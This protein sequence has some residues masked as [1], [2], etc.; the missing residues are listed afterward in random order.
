MSKKTINKIIIFLVILFFNITKA[1]NIKF[2]SPEASIIFDSKRTYFAAPGLS[3]IQ[4]WYKQNLLQE[5]GKQNINNFGTTLTYTNA[6]AQQFNNF[7]YSGFSKAKLNLYYPNPYQNDDVVLNLYENTIFLNNDIEIPDLANFIITT[8]GILDGQNKSIILGRNSQIILDTFTSVT[9][10][11]LTLKRTTNDTQLWQLRNSNLLPEIFCAGYNA[12][13]TFDNCQTA[14]SE[15]F[16]ISSGKIYINNNFN[17]TGTNKF[18]CTTSRPVNILNQSS[19]N[20][21]PQTAFEFNPTF[22]SKTSLN[23]T[24]KS[25]KI[26]L[27]NSSLFITNTGLNLTKGTLYFDNNVTISTLNIYNKNISGINTSYATKFFGDR[28]FNVKWHPF[29][30]TFAAGGQNPIDGYELRLVNQNAVY[31]DY[32]GGIFAVDYG[33]AVYACEWSPDGNYL[34]IG[35]NG[36]ISG[37]EL[38]IYSWTDDM[39]ISLNYG[40][41]IYALAWSPDNNY[42]AVGGVNPD[43]GDTLK[44]YKFRNN[45]A[46]LIASAPYTGTI[47]SIDWSPDGNMLIFAGSNRMHVYE[48]NGTDLTYLI[49]ES[50]GGTIRS[51]AFSPDGYYIAGTILSPG[52]NNAVKI[53]TVNHPNAGDIIRIYTAI[54]YGIN[55]YSA[56]WSHDGRYLAVGGNNPTSGNELQIYYFNGRY[57]SL[58]DSK[59]YGHTIFSVD[60][61]YDD[62]YL[63]IGGQAPDALHQEIEVYHFD[64]I[65]YSP[66]ATSNGLTL[67]N[68]SIGNNYNMDCIPLGNSRV[69]VEN[70]LNMN[71]TTT[72]TNNLN[73][74]NRYANLNLNKNTSKLSI[75][76]KAGL[77]GWSQESIINENNP[78]NNWINNNT[79]YGYSIGE[80]KPTTNIVT[81]NSNTIITQINCDIKYNSNAII[82]TQNNDIKNNSNSILNNKTKIRYNSNAIISVDTGTLDTACTNNS[83]AIISQDKRI[84]YNSNAIINNLKP[85]RYNSNAIL[86]LES[87]LPYVSN[88]TINNKNNINYNSSAIINNK[89]N[90]SYNSNAIINNINNLNININKT[91]YNSNA[92][93]THE[94]KIKY[95]SNAILNL[96]NKIKYNSNAILDLK[97]Q[98][99]YISN[100][101][102][103]N[104]NYINYNSS[105]IINNIKYINYNSNAIINNINNLNININKTRYNSSAIII[106]ENKIRY[107]SNAIVSV[108]VTALEEAIKHNSDAIVSSENIILK[109][110]ILNNS[111]AILKHIIDIKNNSNTIISVSTPELAKKIEYNSNAIIYFYDIEL[112]EKIINNSNAIITHKKEIK[113]NSDAIVSVDL[114]V[115]AQNITNNSNA[116]I[117]HED[118]IKYNSNAIINNKNNIKYNSN[119]IINN[120]NNIN[121][122]S[123]AIINN[124]NNINYNS[125]AIINNKN[126]INYNSNAIINNKNNIIINTNNIR[127]NS[128][129][130]IINKNNI[131]YNSCAIINLNYEELTI[132][133][134]NAI[135]NLKTNINY[136]SNATIFNNINIKNNSNAIISYNITQ[137]QNNIRY[138][139]EAIIN[140]QTSL[141]QDRIKNNS[142]A[143]ITLIPKVHYNSQAIVT[144]ANAGYTNFYEAIKHNS[145]ALL[146]S[147]AM[148]FK[149]KIRYNSNAIINILNTSVS[150]ALTKTPITGN[151][152]LDSSVFIHP[153]ERIYI[154]DNAIIDGRGAVIIFGSPEHAQLVVAENKTVTFKNIQLLRI[155]QNT[156]DLRYN[157]YVDGLSPSGYRLDEGSI[158]LGQNVLFGLSENITMTQG[159]IE[160]INNDASQAQTFKFNGIEGQKQFQISPS[161]NYANALSLADN[162]LTWQNRIDNVTPVIPSQLPT[163]WAQND[164]SPILIKFNDNTFGIQDINFSGLQHVS[165]T[166]SLNYTGALGLLGSAAVDVGNLTYEDF[167]QNTGIQE[168]YDMVFVT[169][170]INN[171]LRLLKDNLLFTGQLQ[172][173]DYDENVLSIDSVLT[174]RISPD[175]LSPDPDRTIPL[176]NFATDFLQLTSNY[177][178]ARLIFDDSRIRIFNQTDAFKVYENSYLGGKTIEITGDP[179]WDL[180]NPNLGG[181]EFVLDVNELIGLDDI[182]NKPIVSLYYLFLKNNNLKNNNKLKTALDLVCE[183]EISNILN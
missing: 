171:I 60:W 89:N 167:L 4:G 105:A 164:T 161:N 88:A 25:S 5:Y 22:S 175:P 28:I 65:P 180:Y 74:A 86:N 48:F 160:L 40:Q 97:S 43:T 31:V 90:I 129:S 169:Q 103:N 91:R 38:Q 66:Q 44:I 130:I 135:I 177:G 8:S 54:N 159:L 96:N 125:S 123:S 156:I 84:T 3:S 53:Y 157:V 181:K 174:E 110:K 64:Y 95:N 20:I 176:V 121:Y 132:N 183:Q 58:I 101:T 98:L 59:N 138:N 14:F 128:T 1:S 168:S 47:Y 56:T 133:N 61:S 76:N 12:N 141:I 108:D 51:V 165:K 15:D 42:L 104:K 151:L 124:V 154:A 70:I 140:S 107:N 37:N 13:I 142:N 46:E 115:I 126:N 11:N 32:M 99:P 39:I 150:T 111:N 41:T 109:Q 112:Q 27:N 153:N 72:S 82:Y 77:A 139:S 57:L 120:L 55:A 137:L 147:Q 136:S 149:N 34:A 9:F 122:N 68:S 35:G 29:D 106:H 114:A 79:T 52:D 178:M 117:K 100:A 26:Y 172:F 162:G 16:N 71:N 166:D 179:I 182:D 163:R 50:L 102:I 145:D 134:S 45:T 2:H 75:T 49:D 67:G 127:Y 158:K 19:L 36:P 87:Q 6:P 33:T 24:D 93:I 63:A 80:T 94:N 152:S 23:F 85:I 18:V 83:N 81:N 173:S 7:I 155:N 92:I 170:A 17:I 10:R 69:I 21:N 62:K 144:D 119:A 118:D 143:I 148:D 30:Y 73:F 113:Y 146:N 116:I 78:D 131:H